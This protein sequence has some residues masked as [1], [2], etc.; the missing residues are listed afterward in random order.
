MPNC[1]APGMTPA[2]AAAGKNVFPCTTVVSFAANY[3][4]CSPGCV[5]L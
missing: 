3:L 1:K 2:P 4:Y 5:I